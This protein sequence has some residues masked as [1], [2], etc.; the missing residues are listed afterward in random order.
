MQLID[1]KALRDARGAVAHASAIII[2]L[3]VAMTM[4]TGLEIALRSI[5]QGRD[6]FARTLRLAD[7]EVRL[8]AEDVR[9]LPAWT[10]CPEL[11]MWN[12]AY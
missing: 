6:A 4:P 5:V 12:R 9:N 1:K 3:A 10:T 11:T 2:A 7:L 8:L